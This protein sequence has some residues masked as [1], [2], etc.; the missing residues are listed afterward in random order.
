MER[1][2]LFIARNGETNDQHCGYSSGRSY[3]VS[4]HHWSPVK[5]KRVAP[6]FQTESPTRALQQ[7][8]ALGVLEVRRC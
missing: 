1:K 4:C 8:I 2:N 6:V 5:A 3:S 7:E